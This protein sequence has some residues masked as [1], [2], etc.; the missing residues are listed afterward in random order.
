MPYLY[1][2]VIDK[3]FESLQDEHTAKWQY[4]G[5]RIQWG[6][7]RYELQDEQNEKVGVGQPL[8]L[9]EEIFGQKRDYIVFGRGHS[10]IL[11][12]VSNTKLCKFIF[13]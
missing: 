5:D 13:R 11:Y 10:I 12:N 2:D 9:F 7:L 3:I 4:S 8:K 6:Y 1:Y